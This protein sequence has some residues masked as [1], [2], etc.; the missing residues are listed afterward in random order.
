MENITYSDYWQEIDRLADDIIEESDANYGDDV[1]DTT[2]QM[3]DGHQWII[4]YSYNDDVIRHAENGDAWEDC[5]SPEDIGRVVVDQGMDGARMAQAFFA[6]LAD[7]N[8]AV[9]D[10]LEDRPWTS[11]KIGYTPW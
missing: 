4:Y 3:V 10:K 11:K 8:G 2:H 6:M 1:F 5:Y 7:V 9:H